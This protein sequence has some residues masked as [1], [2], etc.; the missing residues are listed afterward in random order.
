[1][2]KITQLYDKWLK[3]EHL[4]GPVIA[5]VTMAEIAQFDG[6]NGKEGKFVLHFYERTLK[7]LILNKTNAL[8]MEALTGSDDEA[9][10]TNT[11]VMITPSKLANGNGTIILSAPPARD[12]A[13]AAPELRDADIPF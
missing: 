3:A 1:M 5:R 12:V 7:P 8:A 11:T 10:W 6:Q 2:S 4:R 9:Q 13:P